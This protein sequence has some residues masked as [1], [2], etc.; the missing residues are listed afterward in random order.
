M[1]EQK[2]TNLVYW[3]A[4]VMATNC[5][6]GYTL[7]NQKIM[8]GKYG[9]RPKSFATPF[10]QVCGK[11][12]IQRRNIIAEITSKQADQGDMKY[13]KIFVRAGRNLPYIIKKSS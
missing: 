5:I 2:L 10:G 7:L 11:I 4:R 9:F 1:V 13:L 6:S 8:V 3:N 12:V